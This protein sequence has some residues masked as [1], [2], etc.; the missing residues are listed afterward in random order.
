MKLV[1]ADLKE[2][3]HGYAALEK[4]LRVPYPDAEIVS[5]AYENEESFAE[6]L[7]DAQGLITNFIPVTD[8]VLKNAAQLRVIS[9]AA[10]GY[11]MIDVAAASKYGI[12]VCNVAEY[13]TQ[14]VADHALSL[15]LA[16]NRSL[17][18]YIHQIESEHIWNLRGT[19]RPRKLE[20]QT[21]G[22]IGFGRIGRAVAKRAAAF[23]IKILAYDHHVTPEKSAQQ[24]VI[25]TD[26]NTLLKESDMISNHMSQSEVNNGFF[27]YA[28][29]KKMEKHPLFINVSRGQSVVEEDLARALDEN[30]LRGAALDVLNSETPDLSASPFPGRPNVILTPHAA[31]YSEEAL[32]N[33]RKICCQNLK[34][35]LDGHPEQA[36][37]AVNLADLPINR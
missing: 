27:D 1:I 36:E 4:E 28:C 34:H 12:A 26:L 10:T 23:G 5:Y 6:I 18:G 20:G 21:L 9:V 31:F 30:L 37:K 35:G 11:N 17:K 2:K 16:F 24:D 15:I 32:V 7:K 3:L 33:L 8:A 25:F 19:I 29:F 13:C 22:I 14:E